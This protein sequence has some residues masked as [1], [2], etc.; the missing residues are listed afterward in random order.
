MRKILTCCCVAA[1]LSACAK[2]TSDSGDKTSIPA[3]RVRDADPTRPPA[4]DA[5]PDD[6][7]PI[8]SPDAAPAD[9]SGTDAQR[10]VAHDAS[11]AD[12]AEGDAAPV[13]PDM[14]APP[15]GPCG[16]RPVIDLN[17]ALAADGHFDGDTTGAP[18]GYVGSCGGAAG[19]EVVLKYTIDQIRAIT[20]ATD[21]PETTAPTVVYVREA[22]D[23]HADLACN[24]GSDAAP[25]TR[26]RFEPPHPGTYYIIVDTG[27][28]MGGGPFRLTA[29][30][31]AVPSCRD[32]RD[33]DGDGRVDLADPGCTGADDDDEVDPPM[34]PLC[35]DGMDNDEDGRV[36]YPADPDCEAAGSDAEVGL[37]CDLTDNIVVVPPMGGQVPINTNG[38]A[39]NYQG[40]CGGQGP[41]QVVAIRTNVRANL[42]FATIQEGPDTL[43]WVRRA[44]DDGATEIDCNDDFNGVL[45]EVDVPAAEPGTYYLFV[46]GFAGQ[47]VNTVAQITVTP[48]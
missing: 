27:S 11:T 18:G 45:S 7:A 14:A 9:A 39:D 21:F 36:D 34:P 12:A 41:E 1:A 35:S 24:R 13:A 10:L 43:I 40:S 31:M 33:N 25:G 19:G 47:A 37:R 3:G 2:D 16:G 5:T 17:A 15:A 38:L 30:E 22:C 4:H 20:L 28:R 42:T 26:V 48:L 29:E 46:D 44:C 23:D 6:A 32:Q 8:A